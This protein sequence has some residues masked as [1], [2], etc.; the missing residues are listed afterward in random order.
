M[1]DVREIQ[2]ALKG[3]GLYAGKIDGDYGKITRDAVMEFQEL[4]D[5]QVDGDAGPITLRRLLGQ[6][7][8]PASGLITVDVIKKIAPNASG[9]I[10]NAIVGNGEAIAQAGITTPLRAA[11]FLAQI[12]TETG[13]LRILE[14]NLN[15]SA[16]RLTQV[17]PSRFKTL[18]AAKPY[19]NNG[20]ALANN[21]YGGRLGNINPNDGWDY[22][23]GGM[24]QTTGRSNYR[25]A[26]HENDPDALRQ[27][28]P[29]L[30]SALQFWHDNGLNA[31]ADLD[32]VEAVRRRINGGT[33]GID[34]TR[35]YLKKA[36]AAL[37]A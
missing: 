36:K 31:L 15:Y 7:T 25:R 16:K 27:P 34:E 10:V 4:N 26:G 18:A 14:E 8:A 1:A 20:R 24:M 28:V 6:P 12:A 11:H 3:L 5:L 2:C 37:G 32:V 21:V 30:M 29:A 33:T 19:A 13:G 9:A 23:G 22:R 35:N 17:W